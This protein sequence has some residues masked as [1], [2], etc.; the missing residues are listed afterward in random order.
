MTQALPPHVQVIQMGSA[1]WISRVVYAAAKVGLADQLAGGPRSATELAGPMGVHAPSLHRLMRTLASLGILAERDPGRFSLTVLG[2]ALR[3]GAPGSA[4]ATLLTFGSGW[5]GSAFENIIHS[6]QTGRTGFQQA[7]G[8]PLFDY[9]A[10]HHD[11]ASLF[12]ETMVGFHS[13]EP[14]AVAAGYDFS[15]SNTI[16]DVG[17]ATGAMLAAILTRHPAPRGVLLDRPHVVSDAPALLKAKGVMD[18]VTI[19]G[20]DFFQAVPAGGDV[21]I[22]SHIIHDWSE[23]DALTILGHCRRA[24][25]PDGHLLIVEM[26]LPSGDV[27][28]PGKLLDMVMLVLAGG[29]ERTEAEYASLL[30]KAGFRLNRVVPTESPVSVIEAVWA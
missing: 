5:F 3:T 13:A 1:Y 17:G 6:V 2:E 8:M 22:L 24:M 15:R 4:R 19:L 30:N 10:Q 29:Q 11:D 12:S 27:P 7:Q 16:V 28:H 23:T 14:P 21:Y 25:K 18:R 20:G 26:V 9:L